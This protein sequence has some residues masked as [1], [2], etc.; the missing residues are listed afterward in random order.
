VISYK[1]IKSAVVKML[2][3]E[4]G[5][6][7]QSTDVSEGFQRPSFF[8]SFDN[9]SKSSTLDHVERSL[10]IRINYFPSDRYDYALEILDITDKLE[11]VFDL[12]LPVLD[13]QINIVEVQSVVTDGVLEFSFD[14]TFFDAKKVPYDSIVI[15]YDESQ[16]PIVNDQG[17]FIT[18]E[19]DIPKTVVN[20][21][22][23]E[24]V[25]DENRK[26]VLD[27]EGHPIPFE[28]MKIL[29]YERVN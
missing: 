4:F 18:K 17:D 9:L 20:Y 1:D 5:I 10:T 3:S 19:K 8:V 11:N 12:K 21:K 13:R 27:G 24:V 26:I 16:V 28:L 29:D 23:V 22:P 14:I 2:D 7:I 6:E 25:T 15:Y